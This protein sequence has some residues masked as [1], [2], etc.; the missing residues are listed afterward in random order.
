MTRGAPTDEKGPSMTTAD[1]IG[2]PRRIRSSISPDLPSG[3]TGD[4]R[5]PTVSAIVLD[6]REQYAGHS[7]G[8]VLAQVRRRFR[9]AG[10]EAATGEM[11]R[12]ALDIARARR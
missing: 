8:V 6:L 2:L 11:E 5:L 4:R 1:E 3:P 10:I 12:L 9:A 7:S